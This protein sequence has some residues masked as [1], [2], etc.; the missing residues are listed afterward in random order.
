MAQFPPDYSAF[1]LKG[2]TQ[3]CS[4]HLYLYLTYIKIFVVSIIKADSSI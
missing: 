1:T 4:L 2:F 3:E